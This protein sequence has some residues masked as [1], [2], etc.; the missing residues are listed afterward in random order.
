MAKG[1]NRGRRAL[2]LIFSLLAIGIAARAAPTKPDVLFI[3]VDDMNNWISLLD[4]KAPIQTP[5]LE[6][7][8]SRGILFKKA[9]CISAACNPSRAATMTGLRPSTSG[10]YGNKSDWRRAVGKRKTIMQRFMDAG[11]QVQGAGKVF[12]H[13]LNGAF[14]DKESFHDFQPMR[15]QT[16]PPRK[17][18]QAPRYGSRNTD[19]GAWPKREEDSIDYR[20][21]SYCAKALLERKDDKP[22]FLACGIF[23]P[24][25]PFFAPSVHH[26]QYRKIGLPVRKKDDWDDLPKG[27]DR[28]M[29]SKKWFWNGMMQVDGKTVGSYHRFIRSYAACASFADAQI[30]RVLDALD[31]SPRGKETI[32][33]LWSAHGFH[34]GEKDHIEK[35]ALWEKSNHVPLIV[36][37]PGTTK[38]NTRCEQPVDLTVLY[39]TLLELCGLPADRE[40]DGV[41]VVPLLRNPKAK[42]DRPA[43]MTYQRGNHAVRS[44]RWRYIRYADG[45]EELYDHDSDPNE[46]TNLAKDSRHEA[47]MAKHR[48]WLPE[49]ETKPVPDLRK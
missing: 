5:N 23:K 22:Q 1:S 30:G 40:V 29:Q 36:V 42:W 8:A 14:H 49:E 20:T 44:K 48:K 43:F 31:K 39:P 3:V 2:P 28:L 17:L 16:Y 11:Y 35:F 33:V 9:Y 45:S 7:L 19:W 26:E 38:P 27:A 34:L 6:R 21:A 32:I 15:P 24:H 18:N 13:H 41:S 47:V 10:I 25:S 4:P 46:W 12:H 37:A